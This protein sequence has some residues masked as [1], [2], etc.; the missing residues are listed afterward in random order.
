LG[1]NVYQ[2]TLTLD[3]RIANTG[4]NFV[5]TGAGTLIMN[6]ATSTAGGGH[7]GAAY[8]LQGATRMADALALGTGTVTVNAG[9][10]LELSNGISVG[11]KALSLDGAGVSNGGA[12]R[13]QS[14]SN[15]Y[16]GLITIG[17]SGA[18][19][20]ADTATS[21]NLTGGVITALTQDVTFGGA[22]AT[23]VSTTGISGGGS[24]IKDGAGTLTL[25]AANSYTGGTTVS[26][27]TLLLSA[28]GSTHAA[29][30]VSVASGATLGG[31]GTVGGTATFHDTSIFTWSLSV[32]DPSDTLS[33]NTG[34]TFA[35]TG[36]LIDGGTTGGSV[37]KILLD[38]AQT[39]A[40]TFWTANQSW[41]D[42]LTSGNSVALEDLF[43]SFSYANVD[44]GTIP[45]PSVGSFSLSGNTLTW[46]YSAIPEPTSA[47][48]G[49]L[50]TAGLL[51]R[52]RTA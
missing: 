14:G 10:A 19:I 46:S 6:K 41:S 1:I 11:A 15:S 20:S 26:Q 8:L 9:A 18:R 48:A 44:T 12:L 29:S 5:K 37:F 16:A 38:G 40:D 32:D 17:A 39:F 30:A 51:R 33:I 25:S 4:S 50:L 36:D 24:L 43:T 7:T 34:D 21:L 3:V 13:N 52:R 2:G 27:G 23:T 45:G 35:V 28:T 47:L 42:V 22:G 49:L 31:T